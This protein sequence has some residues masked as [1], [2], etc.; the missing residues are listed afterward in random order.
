MTKS[1]VEVP[2]VIPT[3]T[4]TTTNTIQA[5]KLIGLGKGEEE[6]MTKE[7]K[8]NALKQCHEFVQRE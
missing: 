1:P 2:A 7:L 3:T 8:R 5:A 6:R 4:N